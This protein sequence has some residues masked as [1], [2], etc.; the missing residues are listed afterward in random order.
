MDDTSLYDDRE[1]LRIYDEFEESGFLERHAYSD[2]VRACMD[3]A[4]RE[5]VPPWTLRG[6]V[7][8]HS[9]RARLY[10]WKSYQRGPRGS[11]RSHLAECR[12]AIR[13]G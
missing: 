11:P 10:G 3:F 7:G 1:D 8:K 5:V 2:F 4:E 13:T 6:A 9:T 12:K